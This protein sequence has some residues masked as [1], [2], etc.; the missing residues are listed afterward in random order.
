MPGVTV[1]SSQ[2]VHLD[3]SERYRGILHEQDFISFTNIG[4]L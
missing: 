2:D 1:S 4:L 3:V